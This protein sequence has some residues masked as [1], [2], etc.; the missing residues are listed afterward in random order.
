MHCE[1]RLHSVY[2]YPALSCATCL[3]VCVVCALLSCLIGCLC[4][5]I[6]MPCAF[7]LFR[8]MSVPVCI[9][10]F[11]VIRMAVSVTMSCYFIL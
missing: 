6:G 9:L 10:S 5:C 1:V 3:A 7:D 8:G 4:K 11:S 2:A